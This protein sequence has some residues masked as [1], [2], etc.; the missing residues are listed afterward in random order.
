MKRLPK[1]LVAF[2]KR[3]KQLLQRVKSAWR[4]KLIPIAFC[5]ALILAATISAASYRNAKRLINNA[6][7]LH[8][9]NEML[10]LLSGISITLAHTEFRRE[11][12]TLRSSLSEL[13]EYEATTQSLMPGLTQLKRSRPYTVKQ[14][15][16][17]DTLSVLIH[18]RKNLFRQL[19]VQRQRNQTDL[20]F[21]KRLGAQVKQNQNSIRQIVAALQTNEEDYLKSQAEYFQTGFENRMLLE[22]IGTTSTFI[23]L[24]GIYGLVTYQKRKRQQAEARQR[25]LAQA[26][27]LSE[28]KLQFYSMV[29]HE[30]RTPLSHILG[31]AQLLEETLNPLVEPAKLKNLYR[32]QASAKLVKQLLNDVLTLARADAG[33]LEYNPSQVELQTFCLNLVED[34]QLSD[35]SQHVIKFTPQGDRTHAWIDARL[36]YSVLSNLLSNAIKYSPS[37]STITFTLVVAPDAIAFRIA[38]EGFGIDQDDIAALYN[39]FFRGKNAQ[40]ATGTGLGL[41]VVQKCVELHQGQITVES[42]VGIGTTFIVSV[43]QGDNG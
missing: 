27:V 14:Q 10:Q 16:W 42:T 23:L 11:D 2:L 15:Q 5:L 7:H 38:D 32:I 1:K 33:K 9:G 37:S 4:G 3:I 26:T 40:K 43:P 24:F 30:F 13:E 41:A 29:S 35:A 20:A 6:V 31:S 36:M 17:L 28:L 12:D 21:Q 22:L 18:Q 34:F 25:S 39:P 19:I 8:R